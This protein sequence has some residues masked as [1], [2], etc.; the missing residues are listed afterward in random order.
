MAP[1]VGQPLSKLPGGAFE[2]PASQTVDFWAV[3]VDCCDNSRK[4]EC[5]P[6]SDPLAKAGLRLL[7]DDQRPFFRMA[8]EQWSAEFKLPVRH[9]LFFYWVKDPQKAVESYRDNATSEFWLTTG[10]YA[11]VNGLFAFLLFLLLPEWREE[12]LSGGA[13]AGG[14]AA[15]GGAGAGGRGRKELTLAQRQ[16]MWFGIV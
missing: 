8:V 13:G 16:K 14:A 1:I 12:E 5:G 7:R 15:T 6:V 4:F 11:L 9:P 10:V 2:L 3:G